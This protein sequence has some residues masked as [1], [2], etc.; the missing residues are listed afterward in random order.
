[1]GS[2]SCS[3]CCVNNRQITKRRQKKRCTWVRPLS[4]SRS[5]VGTCDLLL[6][7]LQLT[8]TRM[9]ANFTK[10]VASWIRF[11]AVCDQRAYNRLWLVAQ[12][13]TTAHEAGCYS[14]VPHH[15][16]VDRSTGHACRQGDVIGC[17][18]FSSWTFL[19]MH[20]NMLMSLNYFT[21]AFILFYFSVIAATSAHLQ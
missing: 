14:A 17:N 12:A 7:E 21:T 13:Y 16:H 10:S 6:N 8:D 3:N 9:Y 20:R 15:R 11:S 4:R 1:M 5:E 2:C 18:N 19:F